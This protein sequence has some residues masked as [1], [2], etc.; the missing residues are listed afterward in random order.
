LEI[1]EALVDLEVLVYSAHK[2]GTQTLVQTFCDNG[3]PSRHCHRLSNLRPPLTPE[4]LPEA[5]RGYRERS[6]RPLTIVSVFR[7]PIGRHISSFFQWHGEGALRRQPGAT[8]ADSLLARA[9]VQEL[10]H[11]FQEDLERGSLVGALESIRE[12]CAALAVPVESLRYDPLREHGVSELPDASL[13]LY[14]FD[15]LIQ[16]G[17]LAALLA[18]LV[19]RPIEPRAA[20]LSAV[21]WY[22]PILQEFRAT[23]RLPATLISRI[24]AEK[25]DL[26]GLMYGDQ[27][28]DLLARTLARFAEGVI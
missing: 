1:A 6:G 18:P 11:R 9:S 23:L 13:H 7:E 12:L 3:I 8:P 22:F 15:S 26:L 25:A 5:L 21:K 28:A 14:R 16:G 20:N 17:R 4:L 10:Q 2:T 24:H 19:G 27:A